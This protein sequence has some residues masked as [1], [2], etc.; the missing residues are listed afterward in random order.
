MTTSKK[1][2]LEVPAEADLPGEQ[3]TSSAS[4]LRGEPTPNEKTKD[5]TS[6]NYAVSVTANSNANANASKEENG[7]KHGTDEPDDIE[8]PSGLKMFFIV[9]A[10]VL[11]IFLL[12][13]DMVSN[14]NT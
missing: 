7:S 10:L 12:A 9:L 1:S 8:Y 6:A 5:D 13:L 14:V 3:L 2:S 11:S 4:T